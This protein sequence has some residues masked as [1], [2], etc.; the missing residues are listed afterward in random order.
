MNT[1]TK[2][3]RASDLLKSIQMKPVN[4]PI[5]MVVQGVEGVGKTSFLTQAPSPIVVMTET[6]TGLDTLVDSG[7]ADETPRIHVKSWSEL[8]EFV[9]ALLEGD[10]EYKTFALDCANG[11]E[12]MLYR[13][14]T[15]TEFGGDFGE[16][17]FAGYGRGYRVAAPLWDAFL[18][19]LDRLRN[20]KGMRVV[21]ITHTKVATFKNPAGADYDRYT[22]DMHASAWGLTHKWADIVLFLN[23]LT[24][25]DDEDKRKAS[26]GTMRIAYC[27]RRAAWDA[28]NRHGLPESFS[29]GKSAKEGW[30]NFL[31]AL[32]KGKSNG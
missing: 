11:A 8:D 14:V 30:N 1:K 24:T 19:K 26:G 16:R 28:K 22:P 9:D 4:R 2:A 27:E 23:F 3:S 5:A 25:I 29:L 31:D 21:L 20:E 17:G 15:Q 7:Q 18:V 6:E 13:H 10:H 32:K 12:A